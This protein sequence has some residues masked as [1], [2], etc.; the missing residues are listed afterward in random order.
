MSRTPLRP[1]KAANSTERQEPGPSLS[2]DAG[3]PQPG[4]GRSDGRSWGPERDQ[5]VPGARP[6]PLGWP[7]VFPPLHSPRN[8]PPEVCIG[9]GDASLHIPPKT[10]GAAKTWPLR[11]GRGRRGSGAEAR[12]A[13]NSR[14][15]CVAAPREPGRRRDKSADGPAGRARAG[16]RALPSPLWEAGGRTR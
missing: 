5:P 4:P 12:A 7:E 14:T 2:P 6:T 8:V 3:Q 11:E 13:A 15:S 1:E 10:Q 9:R 16:S